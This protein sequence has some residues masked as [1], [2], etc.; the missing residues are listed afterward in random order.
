MHVLP[1][2]QIPG[3]N[4]LFLD[5]VEEPDKVKAFY[6][7]RAETRTSTLSHRDRLCSILQS[8]NETWKNPDT[9]RLVK[10]LQSSETMAV[11][12]GQ[13]PGLL[14]GPM[15]TMWKA[16]TAIRISEEVERQKSIPCVPIFWTASEDHNWHEVFHLALLDP[17][18]QLHTFSL[19]EHLFLKRQPTGSVPTSHEEVRKILLRA[20]AQIRVPEIKDFYSSGNVAGAFAKTLLWL[21]RDLPILIV[22][23]SDPEL[24]KL[25]SPFF[26]SF[27]DRSNLLLE[28]L[29]KQNDSLQELHYPVQVKMEDGSLPLFEVNGENRKH[30]NA[31]QPFRQIPIEKLSPAALL[32]P[33]MQDFLFPTL[34]YVGGPAE[35]AYFAQLHPWYQAMNIQQPWLL[36][37][38]SITLLPA[39]TRA[40]LSSR[41]LK[42]EEF[43]MKEDTL[44]DALINSSE[45][46]TLKQEIKSLRESAEQH[47]GKMK[48]TAH[49]VDPTLK[50]SLDT[51]ER[52]FHYQLDKAERKSIIAARRKND[53]LSQQIRKVRN[54]I[55]PEEKLQERALSIFSFSTRLPDLIQEVYR[56]FDPDAKGHQWID[57]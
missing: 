49:E 54:V 9:S 34:A 35:I 42:P 20:F 1:F 26:A 50:K 5:F 46:T 11:I 45:L 55:Y 25:A 22:D 2:S 47:L 10:K 13:Q 21:L 28:L 44:L 7:S 16:L 19:K 43:F 12:T 41:N 17:D 29:R 23:P 48:T 33:L 38:A 32:R 39:A 4:S 30:V 24:K 15:Y 18:L 52:K 3:M 27:F 8:Q 40:F 51:I 56:K 31:T 57:I 37:R 53:L 6:P 14:T 36:P